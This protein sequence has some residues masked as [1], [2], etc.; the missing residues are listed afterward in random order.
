MKKQYFI[1]LTELNRIRV[2]ILITK[3]KVEDLIIQLETQIKEKWIPVVRYNYAH[4][5]PHC[6]LILADGRKIKERID[7]TDLSKV[8]TLAIDELKHNWMKYLRRCGYEEE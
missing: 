6:D 2:E 3:G 5:F 4:G 8:V 1:D 7:E